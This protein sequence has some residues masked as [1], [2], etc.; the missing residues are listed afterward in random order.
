MA[1]MNEIK[2]TSIYVK[3]LKSEKNH[4]ERGNFYYIRDDCFTMGRGV[5]RLNYVSVCVYTRV[6]ETMR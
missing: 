4:G 3:N 5:W 6:Y 2:E 1:K